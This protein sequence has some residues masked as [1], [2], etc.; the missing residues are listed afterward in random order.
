MIDSISKFRARAEE[1]FCSL[2]PFLADSVSDEAMQSLSVEMT[3][4][5]L[6][7][8]IKV[9]KELL[10][11]ANSLIKRQQ[12]KILESPEI[13]S[14]INGQIS[15]YNGRKINYEGKIKILEQLKSEATLKIYV[16]IK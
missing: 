11:E 2:L 14:F 16:G 12:G 8:E 5:E 4:Q 15:G 10:A 3:L 7:N 6:D 13:E 1:N 9:Y